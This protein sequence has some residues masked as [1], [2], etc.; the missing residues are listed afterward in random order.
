MQM[1][2]FNG[3]FQHFLE[4]FKNKYEDLYFSIVCGYNSSFLLE[5]HNLDQQL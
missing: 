5:V 1:Q 4:L 2:F 3:S